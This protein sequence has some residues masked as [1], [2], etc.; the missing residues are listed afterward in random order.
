MCWH[1][2]SLAKLPL[3]RK[4]VSLNKKKALMLFLDILLGI[5]LVWFDQFTKGLAISH[6]KGKSA[7]SLIDG[8]LELQYLE[9]HGMAF[10]MLQN[11]KV[12]IL[13]VG[14]IFMLVL[15][16]FL[17]KMP[18][19]S[20]FRVIHVLVVFIISG[21][22]GNMLDRLRLDYVVDFIYFVLIDYP[23]FNVADI[24]V[25]CATIGLFIMFLFVLKETDLEFL[26]FKQNRCR[27][28]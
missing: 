13:F 28:L 27:E 24:Y 8:V 14:I 5:F 1:S 23:I 16:F 6:L 20:K 19:T 21:G 22:L 25:V 18:I 3:C 10:G 9:N 17:F 4:E 15:L 11:Q 7:Y 26:N 12:F 2:W